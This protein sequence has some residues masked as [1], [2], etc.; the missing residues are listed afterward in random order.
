MVLRK[1]VGLSLVLCAGVLLTASL[2]VFG[3]D[4]TTAPVPTTRHGRKY[5][6]PVTT[7]HIVVTVV[8]G[9]NGK[10]IPN[11]A[12]V[13]HSTKDGKDE[14]NLEVKTDPDGKAI[15]DVIPTGSSL[16]VQVIANGFAT[17]GQDY[18]VDT[19]TKEIAVSMIRPR[20]QVSTYTDNAGQPSQRKPGVQEPNQPKTT[21]AP[22]P[23]T[24][25]PPQQ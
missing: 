9:F 17:F 2:P 19:A 25:T 11:A 21:P 3:Q 22:A 4:E 18:T 24:T 15:I 13:F 12:V 5:K 10:P 1:A 20:A 14:G 16:Q 7:S 6:A 8:K 23:S